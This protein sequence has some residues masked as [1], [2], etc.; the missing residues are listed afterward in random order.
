MAGLIA[1]GL[2][3]EVLAAVTGGAT[4]ALPFIIHGVSRGLTANAIGRALS[5]GGMGIRRGNLLTLVRAYRGTFESAQA[6]RAMPADAIPLPSLFFPSATFMK[7][8]FAYVLRVTQQ[9]NIT[10]LLG[11]RHLT[12]SSPHALSNSQIA[13]YAEEIMAAAETDY[14]A[15]YVSHTLEEILVDPRYLP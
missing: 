14:H 1:E 11:T 15:T 3:A 8:P 12:V 10:G 9:N 13:E 6:Q 5:L 2:G 4:E 7:N